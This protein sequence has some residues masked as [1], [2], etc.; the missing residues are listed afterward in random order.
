LEVVQKWL[1]TQDETALAQ[2]DPV[3]WALAAHAWAISNS[4]KI[5]DDRRL[6]DEYVQK[7]IPVVVAQL[8]SA[9]VRL[10]AVLNAVLGPA[11]NES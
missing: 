10:A 3:I 9:G 5:P 4:Y 1:A 7:N 11:Q 2:G 8:G 6:G